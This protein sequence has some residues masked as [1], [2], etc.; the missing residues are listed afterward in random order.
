M[1]THRVVVA[2]LCYNTV[3]SW[4]VS[5]MS[6]WRIV[7]D[8]MPDWSIAIGWVL[9][10]VCW[11]AM[12]V[13][14]SAV[15]YLHGTVNVAFVECT[16]DPASR[17]TTWPSSSCSLCHCTG[18]SAS[19]SLAKWTITVYARRPTSRKFGLFVGRVNVPLLWCWKNVHL[20]LD[21]SVSNFLSYEN[22]SMTLSHFMPSIHC[23]EVD[24]ALPSLGQ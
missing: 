10:I 23:T 13:Y 14:F 21:G 5:C 22:P 18:F 11:M 7:I 8:C 6:H 17:Y 19:S 16:D 24:S 3:H 1:R 4:L 12:M 15:T 9:V 20:T 2:W